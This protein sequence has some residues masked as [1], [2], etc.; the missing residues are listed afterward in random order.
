M[1]PAD[2]IA[3]ITTNLAALQLEPNI[4]AQILAAVFAPRLRSA[5]E[6]PQAGLEPPSKPSRRR[7]SKRARSGRRK[8]RYR[9]SAPSEAR[10]RA[11]AAL[12]DNPDA[13][14]TQI[15]KLAKP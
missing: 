6:I 7:S 13:T 4:A 10:E 3:E 15:A 9:R 12:R 5:Q 14:P 8:R 1:L 11:I 2:T